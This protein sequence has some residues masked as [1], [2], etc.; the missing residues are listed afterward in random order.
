MFKTKLGGGVDTICRSPGYK[1]D[2]KYTM[3]LLSLYETVNN[4]RGAENKMGD[5]KCGGKQAVKSNS[6]VRGGD[7]TP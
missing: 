3:C 7:C 1:S 6:H 4:T 5:Y 2:S